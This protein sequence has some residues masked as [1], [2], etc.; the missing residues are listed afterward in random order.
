MEEIVR[1][2]LRREGNTQGVVLLIYM[3]IMNVSV[4]LLMVLSTVMQML[5][6]LATNSQA[7]L[8]DNLI[9]GFLEKAT[10]TSNWGY[11]LAIG[12]GL[13]LILLWKK[14]NYLCKTVFAP[15]G[16]MKAKDFLLI[17]IVF[18]S[19]Q[20]LFQWWYLLL[21]SVSN[22]LGFSLETL[23]ESA[24]VSDNSIP[25][26]LYACLLGP[27]AE[28]ILFRGL[29]LRSLQPYGKKF[30]ILVSSLLFGLF[31]GNLL[32]V[33]FAFF[34]G[35]VMG[36]VALEYN[37]Y[38]A[39]ILHLMNNLVFADLVPRAL[40][41][42]PQGMDDLILAVFLLICAVGTAVILILR[43]RDVKDYW[44]DNPTEKG[45]Y[46]AFFRAPAMIAFLIISALT[47]ISLPTLALLQ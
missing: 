45:T 17:T 10:E 2:Q 4:V 35:L 37:I 33:P 9:N 19:G 27:V 46:A 20:Q 12:M 44:K 38:W 25:M 3:G 18:F 41:L 26:F 7:E 11:L 40:S 29:M 21:E 43:W 47:I 42:L 32:Q 6:A 23:L 36:Y 22:G 16:Q 39:I 14:P 34:V 8:N 5:S 1:T 15:G 13:A 28:E 24:T 31:H 30:A